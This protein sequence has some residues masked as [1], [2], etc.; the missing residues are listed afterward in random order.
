M[1]ATRPRPALN[2][3]QTFSYGTYVKTAMDAHFEPDQEPKASGR[4]RAAMENVP[5]WKIG[6]AAPSANSR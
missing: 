6:A 3:Y 2:I 1:P 4:P 5:R